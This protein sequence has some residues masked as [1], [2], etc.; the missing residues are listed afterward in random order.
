[1]NDAIAVL[2][3]QGAVIVDPADIPS[4]VDKDPKNNLCTGASAPT[5]TTSRAQ[6]CS[7]DFAYGM[8]RDFNSGSRPSARPRRVK[9]LTE[10]R[11]WNTAHAKLGAHQ[12]RPVAARHLRRHGPRALSHALRIRP[13]QRHPPHRHAR[14]RRSDEGEP[15]RRPPLPRPASAPPSPHVPAIRR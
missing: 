10:L 11:D 9:S 6:N 3:A 15:T 4:I 7:I 13:R 14:H 12:V 8:E 5:W 2:K 1:M